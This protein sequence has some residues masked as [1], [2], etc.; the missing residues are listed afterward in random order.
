M[1]GS[2]HFGVHGLTEGYKGVD[3]EDDVQLQKGG[4]VT[5]PQARALYENARKIIAANATQG[6]GRSSS[7]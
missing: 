1:Q 7:N 4:R 6:L 3:L 5:L 2:V